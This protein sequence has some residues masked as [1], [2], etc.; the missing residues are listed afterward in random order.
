MME[1]VPYLEDCTSVGLQFEKRLDHQI[2][3][4]FWFDLRIHTSRHQR[5]LLR[6]SLDRVGCHPRSPT[7]SSYFPLGSIPRRQKASRM[8]QHRQTCHRVTRQ[9]CA[10]RELT[11]IDGDSTPPSCEI[12][13]HAACSDIFHAESENQP[14]PDVHAASESPMRHRPDGSA[15]FQD[16]MHTSR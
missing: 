8:S 9:P 3:G 6:A 15:I 5:Q 14:V 1:R 2:H 13:L 7:I 10:N 11:N 12:L 4:L 16:R